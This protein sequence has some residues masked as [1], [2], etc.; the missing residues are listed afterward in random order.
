VRVLQVE[1]H[2]FQCL[3]SSAGSAQF[4]KRFYA[5][6]GGDTSTA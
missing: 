6:P 5:T 4:E 2:S 3:I 1:S